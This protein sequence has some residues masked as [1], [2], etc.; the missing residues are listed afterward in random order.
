[1]VGNRLS[2]YSVVPDGAELGEELGTRCKK[3]GWVPSEWVQ[4][5]KMDFSD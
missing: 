1:M 3:I 2:G 5:F 4:A